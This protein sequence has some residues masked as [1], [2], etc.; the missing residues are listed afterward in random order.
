MRFSSVIHRLALVLLCCGVLACESMPFGRSSTQRA[1]TF[2]LPSLV[3]PRDS[4]EVDIVFVDR[5][6]SDPLLGKS[7][8]REVDQVG[9]LTADQ[10]AALRE[11]GILVGHVG[12]SPPDALQALLKLT[13]E[14]RERQRREANGIPTTASRRVA[15]PAGSD[16]EV[17][18]NEAMAQKKVTLPEGK[19]LDLSNLRGLL[20]LRAERS[21]DGWCGWTSLPSC[22]T[23]RRGLVHSPRQP[24]GC[25]ERPKR[26]S[27][28]S[29][30]NSRQR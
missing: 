12:S 29:L 30:S 8:W 27:P 18:S 13:D 4:V 16:T 26:S 21:L 14:D 24:A 23:V 9:T 1:T 20:R 22:I 17:W 3:P 7:L 10:R 2:K 19:S 28:V 11:A 6:V 15:L 25:I 5:P